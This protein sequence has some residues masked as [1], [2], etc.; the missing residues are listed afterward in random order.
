MAKLTYIVYGVPL[1]VKPMLED[2]LK[3]VYK[4]L[5]FK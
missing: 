1:Y 3:I 5:N 2:Y 4:Q